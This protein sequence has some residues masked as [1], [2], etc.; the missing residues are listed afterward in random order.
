MNN[1][2]N[3]KELRRKLRDYATSAEVELW[4]FLQNRQV[5][6]RKFR[7]QHGFGKF[8]LDFYCSSDRLAIELD[9]EHHKVPSV[10]GYDTQRTKFL[11][12]NGIRVLRFNN[13]EVFES[14]E[15]VIAKISE[16]LALP[17]TVLPSEESRYSL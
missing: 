10:K 4:K 14:I 3:T 1:P 6:G 5:Q 11:E 9:G 2:K 13:E 7:R 15:S 12:R 8:I 17:P 16:E